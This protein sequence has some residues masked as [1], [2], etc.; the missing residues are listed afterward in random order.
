MY[1]FAATILGAN[2]NAAFARSIN[3]TDAIVSVSLSHIAH[4]N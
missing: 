3:T 2:T 4:N 1:I